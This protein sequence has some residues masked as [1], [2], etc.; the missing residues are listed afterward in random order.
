MGWRRCCRRRRYNLFLQLVCSRLPGKFPIEI[1]E[2][3]IPVLFTAMNLINS[4]RS[5]LFAL[6]VQDLIVRRF[7]CIPSKDDV[8]DDDGLCAICAIFV[9]VAVVGIIMI[10]YLRPWI[11]QY[12]QDPH[13]YFPHTHTHKYIKQLWYTYGGHWVLCLFKLTQS[14][15]DSQHLTFRPRALTP[16][17][18]LVFV[19]LWCSLSA[20]DHPAYSLTRK[21]QARE[22]IPEQFSEQR[23]MYIQWCAHTLCQ[24]N[25]DCFLQKILKDFKTYQHLSMIFFKYNIVIN[26]KKWISVLYGIYTA[27]FYC[28]FLAL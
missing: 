25:F 27:G 17:L 20:V 14:A 1:R 26:K 22:R 13:T 2:F 18:F 9:V 21:V 11:A 15:R 28:Y 8:D 7:Y 6:C 10:N 3:W 16:A 19:V 23:G 4:L 24:L 5:T 12:S